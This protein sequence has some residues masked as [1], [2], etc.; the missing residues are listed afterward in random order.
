M[1]DL[2]REILAPLSPTS[3]TTTS[4]TLPSPLS[5]I[6]LV[7]SAQNTTTETGK[8]A[9]A[10][11]PKIG[12]RQPVARGG[13]DMGMDMVDLGMGTDMNMGMGAGAGSEQWT[14]SEMEMQ[15]ILETLS[16]GYEAY[17]QELELGWDA[18]AVPEGLGVGVF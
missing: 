6:P 12:A 2:F 11:S 17:H 4:A 7:S 5:A 1:E 14:M 8:A 3:P 18:F 16:E 9:G 10:S 15:K 13:T